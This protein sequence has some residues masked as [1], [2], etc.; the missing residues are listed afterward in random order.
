V[1]HRLTDSELNDLA[2][3][4]N[5]EQELTTR[6]LRVGVAC[7]ITELRALRELLATPMPCGWDEPRADPAGS[8]GS[9]VHFD[10]LRMAPDDAIG[11]GAALI[12]TALVARGEK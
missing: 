3:F 11:I 2:R 5:D 1:S 8:G 6:Y 9:C 4:S 12:R 10:E 7:L